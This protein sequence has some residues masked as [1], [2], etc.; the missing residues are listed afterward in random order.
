V[1]HFI[2]THHDRQDNEI[3]LAGFNGYA[4]AVTDVKKLLR[5]LG[6]L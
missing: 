1:G 6:Y 5:N 2:D 3:I 4:V